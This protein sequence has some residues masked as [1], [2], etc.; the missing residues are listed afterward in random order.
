MN[1]ANIIFLVLYIKFNSANYFTC[2]TLNYDVEEPVN[3]LG[4]GDWGG[5]DKKPYRTKKQV[6]VAKQMQF[7]ATTTN[8]SFVFSLGDNFYP[9]GVKSADDDRFKQTFKDV[10][11]KD[12]L[13]IT[14]WFIIAGNHDHRQRLAD[15]QIEHS[16][17][18]N[19]WIFPDYIYIVRMNLK[20]KNAIK[21]IKF[22]MID[23]TILCNLYE[24]DNLNPNFL[25]QSYFD[26]LENVLKKKTSKGDIKIL[27]GHHPIYTAMDERKNSHCMS[28]L[29]KVMKTY[30]INTYICGHDHTHQYST[31]KIGKKEKIHLFTSGAGKELYNTSQSHTNRNNEIKTEFFWSRLDDDSAGFMTL[32]IYFKK[33][34]VL[35]INKKGLV[36]FNK[37]IYF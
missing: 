22:I 17:I 23:T 16:K 7:Y 8:V 24:F 29:L 1:L 18:S 2:P 14:P 32:S 19:L 6:E 27:V 25:N 34:I 11:L 30:S 21:Q 15:Y 13:K 33:L 26:I 4:I 36:I 20:H 3:L 37:E 10:Y 28:N 12:S 31:V 5:T 9:D 35:F